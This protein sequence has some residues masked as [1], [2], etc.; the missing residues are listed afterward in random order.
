MKTEKLLTEVQRM[1]LIEYFKKNKIY[2]QYAKTCVV[3]LGK[4][5]REDLSDKI[6][7]KASVCKGKLSSCQASICEAVMNYYYVQ[8]DL[9]DLTFDDV[10]IG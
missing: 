2:K 4:K 5:V 3:H 9:E 7:E 10:S 1:K 8:R 6:E